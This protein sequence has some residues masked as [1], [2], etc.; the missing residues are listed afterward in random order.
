MK[1]DLLQPH[2]IQ[3]IYF[4]LK[5]QKAMRAFFGEF[6][7]K[8]VEPLLKSG[9]VKKPTDYVAGLSPDSFME[10]LANY[11]GSKGM[12]RQYGVSVAFIRNLW[13]QY[14]LSEP[15]KV[16]GP[17]TRELLVE[18]LERYGSVR[19]LCRLK[20]VKESEVRKVAKEAGLELAP[21]LNFEFG[22]Y[23]VNRG[24]RAELY[25][26]GQRGVS[27]LRDLNE[28]DSSQSDYDFDDAIYGKVNVKSSKRYRFR[29]KC[30]RNSP[31]FWTFSCNAIEKCDHVV[32]VLYDAVFENPIGWSV[33][34]SEALR[35]LGKKT[36]T[37]K[38]EGL[39]QPDV[40]GFITQFVIE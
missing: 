30:R 38:S 23:E 39:G 11:D 14:S 8:V 10:Q 40:V 22:N 7:E 4:E 34:K 36:F 9:E 28:S 35:T 29:S 17:F 1:F 13:R 16:I 32:F 18:G 33:V 37:V 26:K 19:M 21:Y 5:N 12:A 3:A 20:S 2:E 15:T 6:Y 31:Y 24:R 27:I 25:W